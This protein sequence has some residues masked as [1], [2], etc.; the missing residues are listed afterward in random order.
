ME[1]TVKGHLALPIKEEET[2]DNDVFLMDE[3]DK[4]EKEKKITKIHKVLAHP[5]PDILKQFFKNCSDKNKEV[6]N[7]VDKVHDKCNVCRRFKKSPARPKVGLPVSSDF[8]ECVALDLKERKSNKE[9][10]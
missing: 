8:N 6:L 9:Y 4:M 1:T 5:L 7:L 3:C 2:L 10:I